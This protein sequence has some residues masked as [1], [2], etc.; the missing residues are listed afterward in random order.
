MQPPGL[1][2]GDS[3]WSRDDAL[4]VIETLEGSIIAVLQ[5]D[6]Y[7]MPFGHQEV[8]HTGRCASYDYNMGELALQFAQR[9]RHLAQEFV[10][11]GSGDELFVLL[12]SGQDDAD[13]G[14]GTFKVRAG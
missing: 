3:A 12:F 5:V 6:V 14:H 13:A 2:E 8:I 1:P 4:V 9:S 7:V 10:S 11:A